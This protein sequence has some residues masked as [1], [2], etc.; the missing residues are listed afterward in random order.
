MEINKKA[1]GALGGCETVADVDE[2]FGMFRITELQDKTEHLIDAMGNPEI[3]MIPGDNTEESRYSTILAALLTENLKKQ[4]RT[5]EPLSSILGLFFL[6]DKN[7]FYETLDS[8]G[9]KYPDWKSIFDDF[10]GLCS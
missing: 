10:K 3:F 7:H 2:I 1:A 4:E 8:A 9:Y 6:T 5:V